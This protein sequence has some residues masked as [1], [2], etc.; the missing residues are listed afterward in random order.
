MKRLDI[1]G[2][3]FH[4]EWNYSVVPRT[5]KVVAV[6]VARVL[7]PDEDVTPYVRNSFEPILRA[8]Q[9]QLDAEGTYLPDVT[10]LPTD[11]PLPAANERL[12]VSD[13]WVIF[14]R[15]RSDSFLLADIEKLKKSVAQAAED[16]D[17]PGPCRTLVMGPADSGAGS[18]QPLARSSWRDW[19]QSVRGCARTEIWRPLLSQAVQRR[20]DRN[21]PPA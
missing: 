12:S 16:G 18:W 10:V 1:R 13:R 14:G 11:Q 15:K 6:I 4:P 5:T 21:H 20:T 19:R 3:A 8:C 9:S 2:D 7:N 17:L